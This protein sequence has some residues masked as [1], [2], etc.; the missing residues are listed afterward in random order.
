MRCIRYYPDDP[1]R[2]DVDLWHREIT[3]Q[4]KGRK[5]RTVKISYD[6]ARSLDRYIRVRAWHAQ[7]HKPAAVA[8]GR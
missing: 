1:R 6:A 2:S 7:A 4:V 3:V 8:R 5:T